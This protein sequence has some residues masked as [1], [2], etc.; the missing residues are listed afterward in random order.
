M[1]TLNRENR[2][3]LIDALKSAY[4]SHSDLQQMLLLQMDVDLWDIS[5]PA[6]TLQTSIFNLVLWA[7]KS[8]KVNDLVEAAHQANPDNPALRE[9]YDLV[10]AKPAP[11]KTYVFPNLQKACG[12]ARVRPGP[13][14]HHALSRADGAGQNPPDKVVTEYVSHDVRVTCL[15]SSDR[16]WIIA[17]YDAGC[18]INIVLDADRTATVLMQPRV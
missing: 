3:Q 1:T 5:S 16:R 4:P 8:G 18:Q 11:H 14:G 7:E 2:H 12:I 9:F 17:V 13:A 15:A 6:E 10:W